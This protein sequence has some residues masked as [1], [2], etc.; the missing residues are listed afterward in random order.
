MVFFFSFKDILPLW[1]LWLEHSMDL[2][3][4]ETENVFQVRYLYL[5]LYSR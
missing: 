4:S 1:N 5:Q 3:L 2:N